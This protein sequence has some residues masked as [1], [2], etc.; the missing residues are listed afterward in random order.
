MEPISYFL[1]IKFQQMFFFFLYIYIKA[2]SSFV[3]LASEV[4]RSEQEPPFFIDWPFL[5]IIEEWHQILKTSKDEVIM[6]RFFHIGQSI[7]H[8]YILK[9]DTFPISRAC[10]EL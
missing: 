9:Q 3:L 2:K 6:I 10:Q 1:Q 5:G 4:C 8:S 7:I